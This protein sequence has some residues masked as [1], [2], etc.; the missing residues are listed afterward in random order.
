MFY[1]IVWNI[2]LSFLSPMSVLDW[3]A[4]D[5]LRQV[6]VNTDF[7]A[8]N[9]LGPDLDIITYWDLMEN[10]LVDR[11]LCNKTHY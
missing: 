5:S 3:I 6:H 7:A 10:G 8:S 11:T 9:S 1:S 4:D 2:C